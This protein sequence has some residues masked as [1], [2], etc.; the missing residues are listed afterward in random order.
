MS[1]RGIQVDLIGAGDVQR[2]LAKART[3]VHVGSRKI[4]VKRALAIQRDAKRQFKP[5]RGNKYRRGSRFHTASAPGD[6]PAV[7]TGRYRGSIAVMFLQGGWAAEVGTHLQPYPG[8]LEPPPI[9]VEAGVSDRPVMT[10]AWEA[11]RELYLYDM[12]S[13]IMLIT[14][15]G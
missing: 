11:Q 9:G 12:E 7:D 6:G 15:G 13:L 10:P 4:I 2:A 14:K 5:G 3:Q 8:Y 1:A